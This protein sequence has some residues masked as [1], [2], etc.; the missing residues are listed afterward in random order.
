[1]KLSLSVPILLLIAFAQTSQMTAQDT[2][3]SDSLFVHALL[4]KWSDN[5]SLDKKNDFLN[6]F[7]GLPK[8][9]DGLQNVGIMD[10]SSSKDGFD[11]LLVLRFTSIEALNRYQGHPDHHLIDSI[12]PTVLK[13]YNYF[14]YWE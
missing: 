2:S 5:L 6:L 3:A 14:R 7:K 10:V 9:I 11:N 1:M 4:Y 13:Q 12:G 8:K